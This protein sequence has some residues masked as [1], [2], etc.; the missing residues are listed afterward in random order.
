MKAKY[1]ENVIMEGQGL[2]GDLFG[3]VID[4]TQRFKSERH[5]P[6]MTSKG[7]KIATYTGP[8]TQ[9]TRRLQSSDPAIRD[10]LGPVDTASQAHDIRYSMAETIDDIRYADDKMIR[11]LKEIE[12]KNEDYKVNTAVVR[13]LMKTKTLYEDARG[14]RGELFSGL[15]P[16]QVKPNTLSPSEQSLYKKKLTELEMLGYGHSNSLPILL[17]NYRN[18]NDVRIKT[19]N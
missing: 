2:I 13:G 6:L 9:I 5:T 17:G 4:K 8:N 14:K 12:N 11:K 7:P 3:K 15:K 1:Y 16:G 18:L 10:P 19:R